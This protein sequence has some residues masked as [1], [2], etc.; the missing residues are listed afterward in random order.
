MVEA[1]VVVVFI[2]GMIIHT[3]ILLHSALRIVCDAA[4]AGA[5]AASGGDAASGDGATANTEI[6]ASASSVSASPRR[7]LC[8][9]NFSTCLQKLCPR[10]RSNRV[11][12]T[13]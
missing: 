8:L 1:V 13:D 4:A 6:E 2:F 3:D 12:P 9:H 10:R 11:H 7:R 5:T